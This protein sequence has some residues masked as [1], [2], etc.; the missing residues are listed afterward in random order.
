V[1]ATVVPEDFDHLLK[2]RDHLTIAS[3]VPGRVRLKFDYAIVTSAPELV[4]RGK[5]IIGAIRG[6]HDV[7][8]SLFGQSL[9]IEYDPQTLP[10]AW[11][12]KLYGE[13]EAA[14]R[15]VVAELKQA[16]AAG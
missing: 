14:A 10:P 7:D 11:W 15:E 16:Y 2:G 6:I 13:D 9:T 5:E 8:V 3:H 12:D 1:S 4:D